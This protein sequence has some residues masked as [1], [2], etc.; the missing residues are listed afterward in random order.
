M[1]TM[2]DINTNQKT[3][4]CVEPAIQAGEA[5]L[6]RR[7]QAGMRARIV[8]GTW[9]SGQGI[10]N[11]TQ[12]CSEF[13]TT[14]VTLDKAIQGLVSEGLLRSAGRVGTFV[15]RP[16]DKATRTLKIGVVLARDTIQPP[17]ISWCSENFYFGPLFQGIRDGVSG[18]SV[19]TTFADLYHTEYVR[20]CRDNMMDGLILI[21]LRSLQIPA[22]HNLQKE[23]IY[24]VAPGISSIDPGDAE[25]PCQDTDNRQGAR[26]AA[27]H[28]LELGHRDIALVTLATTLSNFNDRQQGYLHALAEAGL[29]LDPRNVLLL[30]EQDA[31]R[32]EVCL[33]DWLIRAVAAGT[34]PTAILVGDYP[35]TLTMLRVLR[36]HHLRVPEDISIVGFDDPFSAEHLTPPLTTVRQ[37]VYQMGRRATERLLDGIRGGQPPRGGELLR[38]ELIVRESTG[39]ASTARPASSSSSPISANTLS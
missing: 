17:D 20:F 3:A 7:I 35:M 24:F 10:P 16:E 33:D 30:A 28:L 1:E 9:S 37:P 13:S 8:D 18:M 36:R 23:G 25:L 15:S 14:R 4:S 27:M 21:A 6:Y 22:F 11:R 12:L 38:T 31:D 39:R 5:L 26:D 29:V 2:Q 34:V 19:E 32:Y